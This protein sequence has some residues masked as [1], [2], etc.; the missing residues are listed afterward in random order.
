[1]GTGSMQIEDTTYP[2]DGIRHPAAAYEG[3]TNPLDGGMKVCDYEAH[4]DSTSYYATYLQVY[5]TEEYYGQMM[6][7]CSASLL[8]VAA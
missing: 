8:P 7:I 5:G 3:E 4:T 1:M 2:G 6:T